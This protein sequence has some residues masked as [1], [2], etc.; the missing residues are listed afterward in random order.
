V[1]WLGGSAGVDRHAPAG[2]DPWALG[3]SGAAATG[4]GPS[5]TP[6]P[7]PPALARLM[8]TPSKRDQIRAALSRALVHHSPEASAAVAVSL[9][10]LR[11][12]A[13]LAP[14]LAQAG[15]STAFTQLRMLLVGSCDLA[16]A[17][18]GEWLSMALVERPGALLAEYELIVS[19][20]WTRADMEVCFGQGRP[21]RVTRAAA[22]GLDGEPI[23]VIPTDGP[24]VL[25]GWLDDH[26]FITS[27]GTVDAA[28]VAAR[29]KPRAGPP[30]PLDQIGSRID[31]EASAWLV[32]T[33]ESLAEAVK[34]PE[35]TA[36]VSA[37]LVLDDAG[38][39]GAVAL[40]QRDPKRADQTQ[41]A[42]ETML[43]SV[44][45][46]PILS[47]ALPVLA[48]ERDGATVRVR[49]RLPVDLLGKVGVVLAQALP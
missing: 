42:V 37:R 19:G 47:L 31:R 48:V 34:T 44:K 23:S 16:L 17:G 39:A 33:R 30:S 21:G 49:G 36:D 27:S 25:I 6:E 29:L 32:G 3:A 35:L 9:L 11:A 43:A 38:L 14:V 7:T 15:A 13:E 28:R 8:L 24:P 26:T 4:P 40:Y 22:P 10:E 41:A 12:S 5:E 46:D 1:L 45:D 20:D 2:P 18:R